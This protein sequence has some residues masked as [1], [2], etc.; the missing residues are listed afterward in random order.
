MVKKDDIFDGLCQELLGF[1][2]KKQG[3]SYE[4]I[5]NCVIGHLNSLSNIAENV[6]K[7]SSY[8]ES[9]F[10]FDGI[11]DDEYNKIK[12]AIESKNYLAAGEKVGRDD[13][14][15]LAGALI[16]QND[17]NMGIFASAT[18][19]TKH[20]VQYSKDLLAANFKPII[21]YL[22]RP[23]KDE[24]LANRIM[25]ATVNI[26][27]LSRK[28]DE[29]RTVVNW[30]EIAKK[31]LL[32]AGATSG[33]PFFYVLESFYNENGEIIDKLAN[34]TANELKNDGTWIFDKQYYIKINNTFVPFESIDFHFEDMVFK[35]SFTIKAP[36]PILYIRSEDGNI[37]RLISAEQIK[38][39]HTLI[40]KS[41]NE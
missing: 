27:Q 4:I 19:Y 2:P 8:S 37:D 35:N 23:V 25:G 26:H 33:V 9:K 29:Q 6:F 22:I 3:V 36:D 30:G 1:T 11:M 5:V 10:Q 24:D 28:L 20:A 14:Q 15:K 16:V 13:I 40:Q 12:A 32:E 41:K 39:Q 38:D 21:L 7:G 31:K 17:I 34:V 18:E